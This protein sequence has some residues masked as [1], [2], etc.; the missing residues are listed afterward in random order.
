MKLSHRAALS[1]NSK[2]GIASSFMFFGTARTSAEKLKIY[3]HEKKNYTRTLFG[4]LDKEE[5]LAL[6]GFCDVCRAERI[7]VAQ[8]RSTGVRSKHLTS[9]R[10]MNV[11]KL[12]LPPLCQTIPNFPIIVNTVRCIELSRF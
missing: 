7:L 8:S 3:T 2:S 12:G 6:L 9:N 10:T 5:L 1:Y 11:S 4:K